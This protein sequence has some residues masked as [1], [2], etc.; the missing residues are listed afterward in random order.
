[1]ALATRIDSLRNTTVAAL[2]A[3]YSYTINHLPEMLERTSLRR[4][5]L[6]LSSTSQLAKKWQESDASLG[7]YEVCHFSLKDFYYRLEGIDKASERLPT[8]GNY[9]LNL[10]L[11]VKDYVVH[12]LDLLDQ[13]A[14]INE[15]DGKHAESLGK[16]FEFILAEADRRER[17]LDSRETKDESPR[18]DEASI[19]D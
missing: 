3:I 11:L 12:E 5:V 16:L 9:S 4:V 2:D 13:K 17:L 10:L 8:Y 18:T 19:R 6:Q 14:E 1:M 15:A 7:R